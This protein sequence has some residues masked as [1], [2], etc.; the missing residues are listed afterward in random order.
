MLGGI[1]PSGGS[2]KALGLLYSIMTLQVIS[3][4][5]NLLHVNSFIKDLTWGVLLVVVMLWNQ[6][7]TGKKE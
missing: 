6:K 4:G 1:S 5:F 2:G 3:S 7:R